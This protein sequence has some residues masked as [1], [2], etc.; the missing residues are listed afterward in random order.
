MKLQQFGNVCTVCETESNDYRGALR[1]N[2]I[3][4]VLELQQEYS[5]RISAQLMEAAKTVDLTIYGRRGDLKA[6]GDS[7]SA[8]K[9]FL[10]QPAGYDD[11]TEYINP[12]YLLGDDT[13]FSSVLGSVDLN[14]GQDKSLD[15]QRKSR[16]AQVFDASDG[17]VVFSEVEVSRRLT[18]Q[19]KQS[20]QCFF[21]ERTY[22]DCFTAID[23][24][25]KL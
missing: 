22:F 14:A 20:V 6:I 2:S 18:T 9:L 1:S 13:D 5:L 8:G 7:L 12:Q 4:R 23:T 25:R 16:I 17:P 15:D 3:V 21:L 11:A 24:R 19:L 10:Q